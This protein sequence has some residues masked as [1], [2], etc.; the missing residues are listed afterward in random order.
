[1]STLRVDNLNSRTGSSI[2]VPS[3][4]RMYLPG[5]VIQVQQTDMLST[6]SASSSTPVDITG[7]SVSITP[8]SATSKIRVSVEVNIGGPDDNYIYVLLLRNGVSIGAG[9]TATG[10]RI[11]TFL[12]ATQ[13]ALGGPNGYRI[14]N[15]A[16][17]YLD[18]PASTSTLTYKL[19]MASPY[20]TGTMYLNRY[21]NDVD[22][23]HNQRPGS[24]ITVMEIAQ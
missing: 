17:S 16:R 2:S 22:A 11:N 7:M 23:T 19:Q 4:T 21:Y 20:L 13:T 15:L 9:T 12:T 1:M 3:G 8:T 5:H 18:S 14:H 10:S 6:W 24:S